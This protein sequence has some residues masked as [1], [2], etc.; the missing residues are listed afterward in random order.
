MLQDKLALFPTH[1]YRFVNP[2]AAADHA[3]W[4]QAIYRLRDTDRGRALSNRLGW[5]SSVPF[6]TVPELA[7]LGRF[8]FK[9]LEEFG[10]IEGWQL[11]R[12][13]FILDAWVNIQRQGRIQHGPQPPE[14]PAQR[15]LLSGHA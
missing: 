15:Q 14:L 12:Y 10:R 11:D 9:C 13:G 3:A 7:G 8:I 2:T 5:Q 1:I 6:H 4:R